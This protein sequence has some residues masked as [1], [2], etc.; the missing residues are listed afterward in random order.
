M[1]KIE[2]EEIVGSPG[3]RGGMGSGEG[4]LVKGGWWRGK[5]GIRLKFRLK[6]DLRQYQFYWFKVGIFSFLK[7]LYIYWLY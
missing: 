3:R 2:E 4:K 7:N 5:Q 1:K 6:I